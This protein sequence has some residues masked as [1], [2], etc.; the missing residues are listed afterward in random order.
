VSIRVDPSIYAVTRDRMTRSNTPTPH[1]TQQAFMAHWNAAVERMHYLQIQHAGVTEALKNLI[2]IR[3]CLK[4][5]NLDLELI[6]PDVENLWLEIAARAQESCHSF[7]E[8]DRG[9]EFSFWA[10]VD[11]SYITGSISIYR[12]ANNEM[13]TSKALRSA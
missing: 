13:S 2:C 7:E 3:G 9:F 12:Y 6:K 11:K 5:P 4:K 10:L 1:R 8:T